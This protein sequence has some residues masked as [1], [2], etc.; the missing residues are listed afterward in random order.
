VRQFLSFGKVHYDPHP[1]NILVLEN[2]A[3]ALL[4]F[5]MSGEI[6]ENMISG[7]KDAVEAVLEKNPAKIIDAVDKLGFIKKGVNKKILIP[8]IN[9]F[10]NEVMGKAN[11]ARE[12]F[13]KVDISSI[14][15][16]I[17]EIIR[18]E[19]F[20]IPVDWAYIGKT[21]S[22]LIGIISS[23][24]PDFPVIETIKPYADEIIKKNFRS[25]ASALLESF[26][27]NISALYQLPVKAGNFIDGI[28]SG[29]VKI[30]IDNSQFEE[31]IFAL[32][33]FF[34]KLAFFVTGILIL[35]GGYILYSTGRTEP[36]L[37]L[38]IPGT[39]FIL[40]SIFYRKKS[41][42]EKIKSQF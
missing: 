26:K 11:L 36:A 2:S 20:S 8:V 12:S 35:S 21:V 38:F 9:F 19:P 16:D 4:D 18:S 32:K 7:L 40:I 5:G 28:E 10:M 31:N 42:K 29:N 37:G 14:E 13:Q 39:I 15:D 41:V 34:V 1:G 24:N 17:I 6:S 3:I 33:S 27:K 23:L 25:A 30:K 22:T